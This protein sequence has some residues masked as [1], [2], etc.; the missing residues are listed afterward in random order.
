MKERRP[1]KEKMGKIAPDPAVVETPPHGNEE[2]PEE[3]SKAVTLKLSRSM[4]NTLLQ[5]DDGEK[6]LMFVNELSK[7]KGVPGKMPLCDKPLGSISKKDIANMAGGLLYLLKH[8][9][10]E[11]QAVKTLF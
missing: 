2:A 4:T 6:R 5:A 1:K 7:Q 10:S 8:E 9:I 11:D 3:I